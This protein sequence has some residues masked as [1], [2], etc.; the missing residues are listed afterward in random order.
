MLRF[1]NILLEAAQIVLLRIG[2][3]I[4]VLVMHKNIH[5]NFCPDRNVV[6][7]KIKDALWQ[8]HGVASPEEVVRGSAEHLMPASGIARVE[9][10][11]LLPLEVAIEICMHMVDQFFYRVGS[12]VKDIFRGEL[13]ISLACPSISETV[14]LSTLYTIGLKLINA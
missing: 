10:G 14:F 1:F 13:K 3:E 6:N 11:P 5:T 7:A 4:H 8:L 12:R 9:I 2:A